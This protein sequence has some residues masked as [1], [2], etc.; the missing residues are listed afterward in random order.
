ML[1]SKGGRRF[2]AQV[3]SISDGVVRFMPIG[4]GL[5]YRQAPAHEVI[6]HWR[7]VRT[8][9]TSEENAPA[10]GQLSLAGPL[11]RAR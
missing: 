11:D 9:R 6:D 8:G 4:R 7:H 10:P 5:S 2:H 1:V 3:E